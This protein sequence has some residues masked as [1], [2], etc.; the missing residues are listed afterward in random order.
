M[1]PPVKLG[2]CDLHQCL[3]DL[4]TVERAAGTG[5]NLTN[6]DGPGYDKRQETAHLRRGD[7]LGVE[8]LPACSRPDATV[9][10]EGSH[11]QGLPDANDETFD[12]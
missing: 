11:E 9:L 2:M 3:H 10:G 1:Y 5:R 7:H 12:G 8:A 4:G 6:K